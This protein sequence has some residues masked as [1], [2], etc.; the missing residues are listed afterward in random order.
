MFKPHYGKAATELEA[1]ILYYY[2]TLIYKIN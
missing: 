2:I 1:V